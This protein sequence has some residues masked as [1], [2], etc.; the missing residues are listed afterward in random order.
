MN[1][2]KPDTNRSFLIFGKSK[3]GKTT[4]INNIINIYKNQ[5]QLVIFLMATNDPSDYKQFKEKRYAKRIRFDRLTAEHLIFYKDH[6]MEM[7]KENPELIGKI[8]IVLDDP[9]TSNFDTRK[10]QRQISDM[11]Y[12]GRHYFSYILSS[13]SLRD[14][15]ISFRSNFD[16][17]FLKYFK[18]SKILN[19]YHAS[20]IGDDY[21]KRFVAKMREIWRS[22]KYTTLMLND[23]DELKLVKIFKKSSPNSHRKFKKSSPNNHRRFKKSSPNNHK[24][25][26]IRI[27]DFKF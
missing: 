5:F 15:N 18:S 21:C 11:I 19:L 14:I 27:S 13:Q 1:I 10:I 26:T 12:N 24:K 23:N 17:V 2:F 7:V 22:D 8:L 20:Y 3:S 4:F 9:L 6:V 25:I 16:Q